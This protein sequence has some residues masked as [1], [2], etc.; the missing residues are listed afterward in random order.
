MYHQFL[1]IVVDKNEVDD[2]SMLSYRKIV[3]PDTHYVSLHGIQKIGKS[4]DRNFIVWIGNDTSLFPY[5]LYVI[6]KNNRSSC[7]AIADL[8]VLREQITLK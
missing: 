7:I 6:P 1:A 8:V 5:V 2:Q 4:R 3:M